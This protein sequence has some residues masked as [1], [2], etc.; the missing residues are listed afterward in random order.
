MNV[1]IA[2]AVCFGKFDWE[3]GKPTYRFFDFTP[4]GKDHVKVADY[5]INVEVPDGFDPR[6]IRVSILEQE[7]ARL[8]A[9]FQARVTEI[10]GQIQELM[11]LE[12]NPSESVS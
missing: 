10:N 6:A 1:Q 2:G 7:R 9:A 12:F 11:A 5:T 8:T 3:H 4:S